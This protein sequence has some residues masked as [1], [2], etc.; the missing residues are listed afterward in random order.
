[1]RSTLARSITA[2]VLVTVVACTTPP[3]AAT[4]ISVTID[5]GD[6]TIVLGDTPTLTATV[7]VT[8]NASPAV[9]WA[10]SDETVAT[11]AADGQVTSLTAGTTTLTA[12]STADAT[13]SGAMT[14]T[15][16]EADGVISVTIDGGD[17]ITLLAGIL[18][19]T[20]TVETTGN[21]STTVTW[22]SSN[23]AVGT[24][25]STSGS[26]TSLT[27]GTT[28]ITAT[29]TA[30]P[31]KSDT[32]T[33]TINPL[34]VLRWTRQFGTSSGDYATGI[35]TDANGNVYA[36]GYTGGAL[37]G[38]NAGNSDAFIRSYD[39]AGNLRWTRQ[40]GT[41]SDDFAFGIATDANGNVYATGYTFGVLTGSSAGG[42][43]A[44]IRSYD[45]DGNLRWTRQFGT[46]SEDVAFGIATD[47]NGNVYATGYTFGAL[48]GSNA[49]SRDA[50]IR[51]YDS[52][53]N[54]LWTRQFGTSSNDDAFGIATDANGNVYATGYTFGALEGSNA[55]GRD[56]FI[57]S[58]DRDGNLRWTRQFGTSSN[59]EA[60]G[61]ATDTNGNVY[62]T[63]Y[64]LGALAGPNAGG[65][66]AFIRSYDR[67]G[68]LLWTR[69]FGTSSIDDAFGI[70]TD[71]NR[72]VYATGYTLG[73]LAGP[74]AGGADAFIR[75]Y[76]RNGSLR[77]TRQFGTSSSDFARGIATDTNN[78]YT[79]GETSGALTGSSAGGVDVFIRSYGR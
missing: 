77:W 48:E 71:A 4:V 15:I 29:S 79:T 50:F 61:I 28:N 72:N 16:S 57:R 47:A 49:G 21:A 60:R 17:R 62:A 75:S 27:T 73:A 12:T 67:D 19:L 9:T 44:F 37:A 20:A 7:E 11:I 30:D 45:R 70:A 63:G 1:M 33:L 38:P 13:K 36:T 76:D 68:N 52:A 23:T 26:V 65:R 59:D 32:I 41:S 69:Q 64:T 5:G 51:S 43:D 34:G 54:L 53:G 35:A 25:E 3:P 74:N 8:G 22:T 40:F 24:I 55:G 6:R 58:Y 31:T 10:S 66:D 14:L 56:A 2:L 42:V 78:V 18:T 46:S 39:S